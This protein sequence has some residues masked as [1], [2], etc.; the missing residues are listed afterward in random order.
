MSWQGEAREMGA[1]L[2]G[3]GMIS[4][5][6]VS[7]MVERRLALSPRSGGD[8]M[9]IATS[10]AA[11]PWITTV[12]VTSCQQP[13]ACHWLPSAWGERQTTTET[14]LEYQTEHRCSG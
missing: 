6:M 11:T 1:D 10:P 12:P 4:S 8:S 13:Y 5:L 7:L 3:V 2:G 9:T 14:I